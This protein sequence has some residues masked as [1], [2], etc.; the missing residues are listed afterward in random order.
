MKKL[1]QIADEIS[2]YNRARKWDKFLSLV[3]PEQN[4]R[5]LDVGFSEREYGLADNFLEKNY[6][7][8]EN[9]TAVGLEEADEFKKRYPKVRTVR[10]RGGRLPFA[11]RSFDI[12]WSNAVIEHVGDRTKQ[13]DFLRELKRVA[14]R[15][16]LTTPNRYFLVEVHTRLPLLHWLP[17]RVFD[18]IVKKLGKSWAAGLYMNLLSLR[19]LKKLL[20]EAGITEYEIH[21]NKLAV[22]TLDFIVVF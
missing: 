4:A 10:Y 9:I 8:P 13:L 12:G 7:Y 18:F 15:T 6:S 1:K 17:K 5:I 11:D 20:R 2:L 19:A 16:F 14:K 21:K 3:R 22:F